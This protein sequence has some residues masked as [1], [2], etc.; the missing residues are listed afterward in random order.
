MLDVISGKDI[1]AIDSQG[2]PGAYSE[3]AASSAYPNCE[4]VPCEQFEAAFQVKLNCYP[5]ELHS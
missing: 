4:A 2:M 3:A 1:T 5:M